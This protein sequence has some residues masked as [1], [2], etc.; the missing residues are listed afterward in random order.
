LPGDNQS[1]THAANNILNLQLRGE[2]R[3]VLISGEPGIG[4]SRIAQ[5]VVERLSNE[6]T[7][8]YAG[9]SQSHRAR[10]QSTKHLIL[11]VV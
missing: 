9:P 2:G 10:H 4:K 3:V 1:D 11:S 6:R 7:L 5:T 8:A